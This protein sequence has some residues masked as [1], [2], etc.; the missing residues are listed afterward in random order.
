MLSKKYTKRDKNETYTRQKKEMFSLKQDIRQV[1]T[2][3]LIKTRYTVHS[4]KHG[5]FLLK[6]DIKLVKVFL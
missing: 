6:Q 3:F 4:W 1:K 2:K 5:M